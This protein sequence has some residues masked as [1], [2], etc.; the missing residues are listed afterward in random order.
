MLLMKKQGT[1]A[2]HYYKFIAGFTDERTFK[3][4]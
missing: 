3:S 2:T 1:A 4:R